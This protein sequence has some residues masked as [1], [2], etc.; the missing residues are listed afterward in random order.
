[1]TYKKDV[2]DLRESPSLD[3]IDIF[4]GAG[5][6]LAYHDP[7]IPYIKIDHIDLLGVELTENELRKH[8]VVVI[9]TDHSGI[10]YAFVQRHA[11]M[12]FDTRCVYKDRYANV[13]RI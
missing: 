1:V 9:V 7:Y 4:R 10:D 3:I 6:T 13:E 8:D 11:K 12:V 2:K 5:A